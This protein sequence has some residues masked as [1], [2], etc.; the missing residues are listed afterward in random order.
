MTT[1]EIHKIENAFSA[2]LRRFRESFE[3]DERVTARE[4][5]WRGFVKASE[6]RVADP[7]F[8]TEAPAYAYLL[9]CREHLMFNEYAAASNAEGA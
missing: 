9:L 2:G 7:R 4:F 1:L 6:N 5:A 3:A 8:D